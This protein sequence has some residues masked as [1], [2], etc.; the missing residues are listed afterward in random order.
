MNENEN[1]LSII[2]PTYKGEA[3]IEQLVKDLFIFFEKYKIEIIIINDCSP[4]NTHELC[5]KLIEEFP[6]HITYLK[7]SKNFGEHNA[8]IAGLRNCEGQ[9]AIIMDDDYQN[10]PSEAIKLAKYS[11]TKDFD[12]VFTK[13][14]IKEDSFIRNL[15]SKIANLSAEVLINKPKNIYLSSFK[16]IKR[17]LIN[18]IIKYTGPYPY[19]DGLILSKTHNIG[20]CEVLHAPRKRGKS[21]Y[22]LIK[23]AKHFSNLM[24]NFST[25]PIHFFSTIGLVILAIS[26]VFLII[27]IIEKI[28]NPNLP[29]GYST[30]ITLIIFFAGIQIIFLGLLGEYVGKIL[31]NIN[32]EKQY[33][34]SIL[35]K[36]D[37]DD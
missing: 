6:K 27:T 22:T 29:Q 15:M 35:K 18:E 12:V 9:Y 33:F 11:L 24:I 17:N 21:S 32:K 14:K 8:V 20:S 4:D 37:K 26:I 19:I 34:I 1:L 23:L 13:Y 2:I 31:K 7:L 25:K 3:T 16:M 36:K 28:F 10:L 5:K 30:L